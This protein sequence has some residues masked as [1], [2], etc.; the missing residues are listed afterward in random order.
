MR[1]F[2]FERAFSFFP[3]PFLSLQPSLVAAYIILLNSPIR[4]SDNNSSISVFSLFNLLI[5]RGNPQDSGSYNLFFLYYGI[6]K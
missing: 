3:P 5:A 1:R 4:Q 2:I 6:I